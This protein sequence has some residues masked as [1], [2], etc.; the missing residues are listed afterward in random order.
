MFFTVTRS[1]DLESAVQVD[2]ATQ[3]GSAVAGIDY[4]ATSGTLSFAAH[5]ATATITVRVFGNRVF[6]ANRAFTVELSNPLAS[7]AFAAPRAFPT[8]NSPASVA[9]ADFNGDGR[10]DVRSEEHTSEL[11]S[12]RH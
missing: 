5:Q 2:Y 9:V 8:G 12:L 3:N 6:Q 1:G 7:A 4:V 11:Q 10:P